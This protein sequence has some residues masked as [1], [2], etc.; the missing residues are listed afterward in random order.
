LGIP[1]ITRK[2]ETQR[3][4]GDNEWVPGKNTDSAVH[5]LCG[6]QGRPVQPGITFFH[7]SDLPRIHTCQPIKSF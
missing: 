1:R 7:R 6:T 4:K 3:I 2:E 5:L